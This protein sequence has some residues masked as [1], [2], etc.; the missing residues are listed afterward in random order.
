MLTEKLKTL[1]LSPVWEHL[2]MELDFD[3]NGKSRVNLPVKEEFLQHFGKVHGGILA[4]H[5]DA[6]M[7]SAINSVLADDHFSV[8]AEMKVQFLRPASG[9]YLI[10]L[11][12]VV[13]VG[14]RLA[15]SKGEIYDEKDQMV[16]FATGTF[17]N[18][19]KT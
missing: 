10:G 1:S 18:E 4:T 14:K 17:K 15:I 2:G 19:L 3:E 12:E 16:A 5:L 6:T 9:K 7:A 13:K 11:G 8:T